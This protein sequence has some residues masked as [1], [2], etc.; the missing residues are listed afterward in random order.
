MS[1]PGPLTDPDIAGVIR[2]QTA[3]NLEKTLVDFIT[4]LVDPARLDNPTLN[5]AQATMPTHPIEPGIPRVPYDYTERA[6]TLTLK[7]APTVA[8]GRVPR[9]VTGEIALDKL[10]DVPSITVQA[11]D[12]RVQL[13]D[14]HTQKIVTVRIFITTYD[15]NP[16]SQGYQDCLNLCETLEMA[17]T[18]FGLAALNQAY[19]IVLPLE[20]KLNENDTFPHYLAEMTTQWQMAAARPMPDID[21][22]LLGPGEHLE[23]RLENLNGQ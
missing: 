23:H 2:E 3:Y 21:P 10:P 5:L 8:R 7:V 16:D 17:L 1:A 4:R 6:Q 19:P 20:W 9:T 15:E 14:S 13:L 22:W 11:V 18:S 12:G